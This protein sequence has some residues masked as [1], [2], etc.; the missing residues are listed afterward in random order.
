MFSVKP[1][2]DIKKTLFCWKKQKS[3]YILSRGNNSQVLF[4]QVCFSSQHAIWSRRTRSMQTRTAQTNTEAE[5]E[6]ED[7]ERRYTRYTQ[8]VQGKNKSNLQ[9]L[10]LSRRR[11]MGQNNKNRL[12]CFYVSSAACSTAL[13]ASS[14]HHPLVEMPRS[15]KSNVTNWHGAVWCVWWGFMF[16]FPC[17]CNYTEIKL[18]IQLNFFGMSWTDLERQIGVWIEAFFI[19]IDWYHTSCSHCAPS[20]CSWPAL[21]WPLVL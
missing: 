6:L 11:K 16:F 19:F 12:R 20:L 13:H 4:T 7:S 17:L 5:E 21:F 2:Q 9:I 1:Q 15:P 3:R 18:K 10:P 14:R 8:R